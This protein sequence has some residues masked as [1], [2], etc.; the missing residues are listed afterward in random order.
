MLILPFYF[1]KTNYERP[2]MWANNLSHVEKVPAK[3]QIIQF[4]TN[5]EKSLIE[6]SKYIYISA[7]C[8]PG[9]ARSGVANWK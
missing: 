5:R 8:S 3:F 7:K 9:I 1:L 4:F 6:T 2:S